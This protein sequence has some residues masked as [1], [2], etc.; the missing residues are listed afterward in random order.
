M[1]LRV[2]LVNPPRVKNLPVVREERYEHR[3]VGSVYPP[4]SILQGAASL[5]HAGFDVKVMDA[6]GFDLKLEHIGRLMSD[7]QPHM[8]VARMAFDC[9]E[10]DLK[11]LDL[12]KATNP[13]C[14]TVIRNKI[15]SEVPW[16]LEEVIKSHPEIDLYLMGELDA[17]LP[18]LA[19]RLES[20]LTPM[21][22]MPPKSNS[23]FSGIHGLTY[24]TEKEGMVKTP[25]PMLMDVSLAPFPAYDMLPSIAPYHTGVFQ[26]HFV[27]I[28]TSRG[29][30][31]GCTFCAYALEKYRPRPH[32]QVAE[33]LIWLKENFGAKN[34]LFFDDLLA[35]NSDRTADL[36]EA[37]IKD[38]VNME[39]VCCTR[40]NLTD[41]PSLKM[42]RK[43]GCR[44]LAVGIESGDEKI[45]EVI[46]KGVSKAD[47]AK[48]ASAC[49]EADI[50]FYGMT[51]CGL[52][53]ETEETWRHTIDFIKEIDPFYTQFCFSTPFPNTEMYP[54][55]EKNGY[56]NTKDW[57][58]YSPLAP[59]PVI[60]T[61]ALTT[62]DLIRLR[63]E[64]YREILFRPKYLL[65]KIRLTDPIWNIKGGWELAKRGA[66]VLTGRDVR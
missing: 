50:L 18:A 24:Y 29:C 53:G 56:L 36:A 2:L 34:V 47:I 21:G 16:L 31:F 23:W 15:I 55:Y 14:V 3:D 65:S 30:P 7:W 54:F 51:I 32:K 60:R 57:S 61:E 28:Q 58:Q 22:N 46:N 13:N 6:N 26:D 11:V 27:M 40:A 20:E 1:K 39:W 59:T 17:I 44:E 33:E 52:P 19:K 38:E 9:Q 42:M 25:P 4:L 10:E 66:A 37:L 12:A 43:S 64:A 45:L 48:C 8:V 49:K 35:L 41:V 63:R 5:R 62:Q